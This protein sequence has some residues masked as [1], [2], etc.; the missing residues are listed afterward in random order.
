MKLVTEIMQIQKQKW[1]VVNTTVSIWNIQKTHTFMVKS[2]PTPIASVEMDCALGDSTKEMFNVHFAQKK[3][4]KPEKAKSK[5]LLSGT[6][7][8]LFTIRSRSI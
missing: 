3:L 4:S 6:M 5:N 7:E 1:F 2:Q 8:S